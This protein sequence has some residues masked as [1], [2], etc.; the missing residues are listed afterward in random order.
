[1]SNRIARLELA[2]RI[3]NGEAVDLSA[4]D[5]IERQ[6]IRDVVKRVQRAYKRTPGL[7][8]EAGDGR[9]DDSATG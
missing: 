9:A 4:F 2:A 1:M 7:R 8:Q 6:R 5:A 3:A